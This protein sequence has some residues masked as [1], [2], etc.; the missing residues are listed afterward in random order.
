[1]EITIIF[2][3]LPYIKHNNNISS[4]HLS[5]ATCLYAMAKSLKPKRKG[6][7]ASLEHVCLDQ[8]VPYSLAGKLYIYQEFFARK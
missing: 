6:L 2:I 4:I 7:N 3:S 5:A 8:G 1:M